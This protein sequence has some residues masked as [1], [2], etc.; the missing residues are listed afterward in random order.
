M[1]KTNELITL[2]SG[3]LIITSQGVYSIPL[4]TQLASS[5]VGWGEQPN[6]PIL[7]NFVNFTNQE[8]QAF[9]N[10][11]NTSGLATV[12]PSVQQRYNRK[13]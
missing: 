2:I 11:L 13:W 9:Q 6:N 4:L 1:M 12:I 7:Q 8:I 10:F 3:V 5:H